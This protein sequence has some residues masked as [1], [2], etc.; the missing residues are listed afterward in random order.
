MFSTALLPARKLI[1]LDQRP[2]YILL[3]RGWGS[4]KSMGKS[5]VKRLLSPGWRLERGW[6]L[7]SLP[8]LYPSPFLNPP[9]RQDRVALMWHC[10]DQLKRR[11][12]QFVQR[13]RE[14]SHDVQVGRLL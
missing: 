10:E 7:P 4:G 1:A 14:L 11:Y 3:E 8:S 9:V 13:L 5:M 2:W 12:L 6:F